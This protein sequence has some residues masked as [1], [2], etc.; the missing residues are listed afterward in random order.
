M[1]VRISALVV[2]A[3]RTSNMGFT[4]KIQGSKSCSNNLL[5]VIIEGGMDQCNYKENIQIKMLALNMKLPRSSVFY[6]QLI[7]GVQVHA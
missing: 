7:T 6:R 3:D 5:V 1:Y 4:C 2:M